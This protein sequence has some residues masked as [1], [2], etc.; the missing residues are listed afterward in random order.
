MKISW[1]TYK[2]YDYFK[3]LCTRYTYNNGKKIAET[4]LYL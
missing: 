4:R 3:Y 2:I 1:K